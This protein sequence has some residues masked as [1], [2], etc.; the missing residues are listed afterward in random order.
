[1]EFSYRCVECTLDSISPE[2][3]VCDHNRIEIGNGRDQFESFKPLIQNWTMFPDWIDVYPPTAIEK[4]ACVAVVTKAFSLWW[5]NVCKIVD[6]IDEPNRFG[7]AYGT[8]PQ[9]V[10]KGEERFLLELDSDGRV[11]YDLLAFSRPNFWATKIGYPL[12]RRM[13][14]KFAHDSKLKMK[15]HAEALIAGDIDLQSADLS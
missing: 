5:T 2:N 4:G 6:T 12:A 8:L 1:M 3:Y 13:Q 10:E 15:K 11:N 7:F 9:H 14:K